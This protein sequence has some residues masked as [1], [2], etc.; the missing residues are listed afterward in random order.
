MAK[1][2]LIKKDPNLASMLESKAQ[3]HTVKSFDS[4]D[5]V[6][7]KEFDCI[8]I[9]IREI[10]QEDLAGYEKLLETS[11]ALFTEIPPPE[12]LDLSK[13]YKLRPPIEPSDLN[14]LLSLCEHDK[15]SGG[16]L[17]KEMREY[18]RSVFEKMLYIQEQIE[19]FDKE[20]TKERLEE[21]KKPIHKLA[22]SGGLYGFDKVSILC[23]SF[24]RDLNEDIA[25]FSECCGSTKATLLQYVAQIKQA[26]LETKPNAAALQTEEKS[27]PKSNHPKIED[28]LKE[29]SSVCELYFIDDDQDLLKV[30]E[31][32]AKSKNIQTKTSSSFTEALE[33][34]KNPDF[35]PKFLL[36]DLHSDKE[37]ISGYD[38]IKAFRESNP[39]ASSTYIGILSAQ[40]ELTDKVKASELGID[41]FFEKPISPDV[42]LY[43]IQKL[44]ELSLEEKYSILL[45]DDDQDFCKVVESSLKGSN[46]ELTM[47]H[48]GKDFFKR[49]ESGNFSLLLLDLNLP[50]HNGL[51]LLNTLRADY[52]YRKLPVVI[53]TAS[54]E[55]ETMKKAYHLGIQDYIIKPISPKNFKNQVETILRKKQSL[56]IIYKKDDR[57]NLYT[58][59]SLTDFFNTY[60]INY[61]Y[62]T[63]VTFI[64]TCKETRVMQAFAHALEDFFGKQDIKGFWKDG[65]FVVLFIQLMPTQLRVIIET[66]YDLLKEKE[67]FKDQ[68]HVINS[69]ICVY[70]NDGPTLDLIVL[71]CLEN[72][73]EKRECFWSILLEE[74][75]KQVGPG[76]AGNY[77]YLISNNKTLARAIE[78]ALN[79]RGYQVK[80]SNAGR[81]SYEFIRSNFL[82]APPSLIILD[83]DLKDEDSIV[84]LE[85]LKRLIGERIPLIYLSQRSREEDITEGL[86][87]GASSYVIKPFSINLLIQRIEQRYR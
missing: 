54:S 57:F 56:D 31:K 79:L 8:I 74:G 40:K 18:R 16:E 36:V 63:V 44:N 14:L 10:K 28:S 37:Q 24:E 49:I 6:N 46:L 47:Y 20:K 85:K 22:G 76:D 15:V 61:S 80:I 1:I 73:H 11:T 82:K 67:E 2:A 78:Y 71:K 13:F 48:D 21:V 86:S 12:G 64:S 58:K 39:L 66:F 77:V 53:I 52:R 17:D 72:F 50:E 70:P 42:L 75:A 5:Q 7:P 3:T 84:L 43:Q 41:L 81:E 33:T 27:A 23:K 62:V 4:P 87:K 34:L 45:I 59:Q 55:P 29:P 30:I 60:I 32:S 25:K 69:S 35:H 83:S 51:E 26:F 19:L 9:A 68:T 65:V 38:L